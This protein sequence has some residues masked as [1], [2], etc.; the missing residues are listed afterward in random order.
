MSGTLMVR[1]AGAPR[2]RKRRRLI[3]TGTPDRRARERAAPS[4]RTAT[5]PPERRRARSPSTGGGCSAPPSA[6][7]S[8]RT[9]HQLRRR[10]RML[11]SLGS[12]KSRLIRS[13]NCALT[14]LPL[15]GAPDGSGPPGPFIRVAGGGS[16]GV[17]GSVEDGSG[18][19]PAHRGQRRRLASASLRARPNERLTGDRLVGV[20]NREPREP[21][22][23]SRDC[24]GHPHLRNSRPRPPQF[25]TFPCR[26]NAPVF[27]PRRTDSSVPWQP[28]LPENRVQRGGLPTPRAIVEVVASRGAFARASPPHEDCR[29]TES[30]IVV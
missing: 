1:A 18:V 9:L 22:R 10:G 7:R 8:A 6:R 29:R 26:Q 3:I 16:S 21:V 4:C 23:S 5:R 13:G 11:L 30:E 19:S 2:R 25:P 17:A 27:R 12:E 14:S 28:T 24:R 20:W 15:R